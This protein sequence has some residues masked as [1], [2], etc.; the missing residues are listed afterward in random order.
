MAAPVLPSIIEANFLA[1]ARAPEQLPPEGPPEI[2]I[3]GRSN[4]GKSTLLNRLAARRSLARTSK[5]PGRTRGVIFY[6]LKAQFPGASDRT[7]L[8]LADLPGYGYAQVSHQE[9]LQWR[10]LIEGYV[11]GRRVLRLFLVLLDARRDIQPD[12]RELLEWLDSLGVAHQLVITKVD[13]LSSGERGA[14]KDRVKASFA[15]KA[16]P[17][18]MVSGETG[19]GVD[20]LWRVIARHCQ[21]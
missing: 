20:Q 19:E 21:G 8:R 11:A 17:V 15:G 13:K 9:R 18:A 12:E 6:D 2:A 14:L 4:V 10:T 7:A 5:T 16:P 3:A 1:E